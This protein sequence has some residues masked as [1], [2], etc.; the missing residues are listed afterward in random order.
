MAA[1]DFSSSAPPH[2]QAPVTQAPKPT[3]EM[4]MPDEPSF[5][6]NMIAAPQLV[7]G[8]RIG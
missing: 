1:I 5:R 6:M 4:S 8:S 3:A 7:A 2:I